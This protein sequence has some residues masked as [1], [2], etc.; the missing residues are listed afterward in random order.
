MMFAAP[1]SLEETATGNA[2]AAYCAFASTAERC[3]QTLAQLD[4]VLSGDDSAGREARASFAQ[5]QRTTV[6][7]MY[8]FFFSLSSSSSARVT[9]R[10]TFPVCGL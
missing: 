6:R 9:T 3:S 5:T 1:R 8:L 10:Y 7:A 2:E 4:A